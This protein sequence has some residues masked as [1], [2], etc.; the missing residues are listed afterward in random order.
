MHGMMRQL[1]SSVIKKS[2]AKDFAKT[3]KIAQ[4]NFKDEIGDSLI[5]MKKR[6]EQ[7]L[8]SIIMGRKKNWNT[9]QSSFFKN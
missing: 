2:G 8:Q 5:Q 1:Q 3:K 9:L 4:L 7:H 6:T